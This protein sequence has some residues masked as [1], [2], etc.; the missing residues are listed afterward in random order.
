MTPQVG[1]KPIVVYEYND[2]G[3]ADRR[4]NWLTFMPTKTRPIP[5]KRYASHVELPADMK[6]SG[7][8][9]AIDADGA[10]TATDCDSTSN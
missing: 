1:P 4:A 5:V 7:M 2:P 6:T 10:I 8:I 9:A 3:E